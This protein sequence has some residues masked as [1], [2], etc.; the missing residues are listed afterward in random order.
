MPWAK[1]KLVWVVLFVVSAVPWGAGL[2]ETEKGNR[3][4]Y[5]TVP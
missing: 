5:E 3:W 4:G 2:E 1:R